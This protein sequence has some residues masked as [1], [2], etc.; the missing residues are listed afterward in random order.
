MR[1]LDGGEADGRCYLAMEF[2]EGQTLQYEHP[3][4]PVTNLVWWM[5][6]LTRLSF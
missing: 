3:A 2:V 4:R 6:N 1:T 5:W